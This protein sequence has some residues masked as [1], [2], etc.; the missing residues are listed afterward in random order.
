[1]CH[2]DSLLPSKADAGQRKSAGQCIKNSVLMQDAI[3]YMKTTEQISPGFGR[4]AEEKR[5]IFAAFS[6]RK[7]DRVLAQRRSCLI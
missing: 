1:M 5:A 3:I 7:A 6:E 4:E 2:F